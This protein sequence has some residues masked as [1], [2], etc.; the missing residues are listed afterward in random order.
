MFSL[1]ISCV[2]T[3]FMRF[4]RVQNHRITLSALANKFGGIATP[5]CFVALRFITISN[6][7]GCSTGKSAGLVPLR[8]I[9][10]I[11]I[12][13][14]VIYGGRRYSSSEDAKIQSEI[15]LNGRNGQVS[16]DRVVG[17]PLVSA[18]TTDQH[19]SQLF[20]RFT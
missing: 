5:I 10:P 15:E 9:T 18:E 20:G 14:S 12:K 4:F 19:D 7:L 2:I 1:L 17:A 8:F 16:Q 13:E 11:E 3:L 6:F